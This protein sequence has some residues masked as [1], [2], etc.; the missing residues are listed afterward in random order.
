LFDAKPSLSCLSCLATNP[1]VYFYLVG[2]YLD[3]KVPV[4]LSAF[5]AVPQLILPLGLQR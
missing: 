5:A 2:L 3:G 1:K 4:D